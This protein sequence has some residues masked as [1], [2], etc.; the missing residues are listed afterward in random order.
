MEN[1]PRGFRYAGINAGIKAARKDMA[2]VLADVPCVAAGCFTVNRARAA[3]VNDAASRLPA[4]NIRAIVTNSGNA[5]AL[6]GQAGEEDVRAIHAA[7][8]EVLEIPTD[9]VV[10]ASTG[11]IVARTGQLF[12]AFVLTGLIG[13]VGSAIWVFVVGPVRP[14]RWIAL[15]PESPDGASVPAS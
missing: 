10:S 14:A 2:L 5:N 7:F 3:P 1:V 9:S 12:W 8:A 4:D 11:V 15:T 6:T 13:V